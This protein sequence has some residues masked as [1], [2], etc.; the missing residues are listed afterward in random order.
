[1][2]QI[3]SLQRRKTNGST[4]LE[5]VWFIPLFVV[6]M[7]LSVDCALVC[8]GA[9]FNDLLCRD[10]AR[11]AAQKTTEKNA[12]AAARAVV[13][14]RKGALPGFM[15]TPELVIE[16]DAFEYKDF[17]NARG[18][19][20][21]DKGPFVKVTTSTTITMPIPILFN[22]SALADNITLRQSYT[23]PIVTLSLPD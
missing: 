20:D 9:W 19:P 23:F 15:A 21:T 7:F 4:F 18:I 8:F 22:G 12:I 17:L 1:M 16:G 2:K 6:V 10:A 14:S 5:V 11:A 13:I 3:K